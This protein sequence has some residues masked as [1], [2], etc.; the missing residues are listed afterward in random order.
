MKLVIAGA[1]LFIGVFSAGVASRPLFDKFSTADLVEHSTRI[2]EEAGVTDESRY[3][4]IFVALK[5]PNRNASWELSDAALTVKHLGGNVWGVNAEALRRIEPAEFTATVDLGNVVVLEGE[6][7]SEDTSQRLQAAAER[8]AGVSEVKNQLLISDEVKAPEWKLTGP[9]Y[10]EKFLSFSGVKRLTADQSGLRLEGEVLSR[11]V[12]EKLGNEANNLADTKSVVS[13]DLTVRKPKPSILVVRGDGQKLSLSGLLPSEEYHSKLVN[14]I[15]EA[16]PEAEI[17]S[18]MKVEEGVIDP[19]WLA[20]AENLL[21]KFFSEITGQ[22][23]VEY[24]KNHLLISGQIS[25]ESVANEL[26]FM[27]AGFGK[28]ENFGVENDLVVIPSES[29]EV[30]LFRDE[31]GKLVVEGQVSS[32]VF[33]DQ[34]LG[35]L[36]RHNPDVVVRDN[37][38][39]D[40][41]VK[42]L[43]W[44]DPGQ[45]V[46]AVMFNTEGGMLR[47]TENGIKLAG[48]AGND[49]NKESILEY[50]NLVIGKSGKIESILTAKTGQSF[51]TL[52]ANKPV[53]EGSDDNS[54]DSPEEKIDIDFKDLA[55]Y[56]NSGR[57]SIRSSQMGN[58]RDTAK[59]LKKLDSN[60]KVIVG[61]YADHLGNQSFNRRLSLNRANAV[62]DLL[63][64]Y[65]VPEEM[66]V[67]KYFGEDVSNVNRNDLWKS[68]RVELSW[69]EE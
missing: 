51:A 45:L 25:S 27:A 41:S 33:K 24:W 29:P 15:K 55:V 16:V 10:L 7:D 19:W 50:A 53:D 8:A 28:P 69:L 48:E 43:R 57:S 37:L 32:P 22:G 49:T 26:A 11:E 5:E 21:P 46:K 36:M 54:E 47:I 39:V 40:D 18:E 64:N 14:R 9:K 17:V 1:L 20:S 56:F 58:I 44:G 3:D 63:V 52:P 30:N 23:G 65:G 35:G 66:M 38:K 31:R 6:V 12:R 4:H 42:D 34:I 61:G 68:R 2:L 67:V 62:K 13:N 59:L 60:T